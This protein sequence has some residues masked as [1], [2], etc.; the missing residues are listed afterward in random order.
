MIP[1]PLLTDVVLIE[2]ALLLGALLSLVLHGCWLWWRRRWTEPYLEQ[3][4]NWL[5][6]ALAAGES[7]HEGLPSAPVTSRRLQTRLLV[8]LAHSL[9]GAGREHIAALA[10]RIGLTA[11]AERQCASRF[12]WLRLEGIRQLEALGLGG[13][14][15]PSLL[16]DPHP[17]VRAQAAEW[18]ASHPTLDIVTML[19]TMLG[20]EEGIST[21]TVQDSLFRMGSVVVH[22]L[23]RYVLTHEGPAVERALRVAVHLADPR[24][25]HPALTRCGDESPAVR[26]LAAELVGA[27]GGHSGVESLTMLLA[28]PDAGV[29][30]A[31][32]SALGKL[33]YWPAV[34]RV[35]ECLRDRYWIVRR[36]AGL[37]LHALGAPGIL[38]LRRA[39][40]DDDPFA[41]DMARQVL[42]MPDRA[43]LAVA[44]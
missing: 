39:L 19:L 21:F 32:I 20:D 10:D 15:V 41:A 24:F 42:D 17:L 30:A 25:I 4:R 6:A 26:A 11:R 3:T 14:V 16:R 18:A 34:P 23:A 1:Q 44:R 43:D 2:G 38:F 40:S 36:E 7:A 29:R 35:A 37:A 33:G 5:A 27:L 28:D 8:N 9:G 13:N 12:W 31:A 22:P